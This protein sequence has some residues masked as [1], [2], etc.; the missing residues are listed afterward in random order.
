MNG[1]ELLAEFRAT[2]AETAFSEL[3]RRYTN[4]V[5]S[6]ANRRV[7]DMSLAQEVTQLV[8]IRLAKGPPKLE[9]EA[10]LLAWLH[11]ATVHVSIDLWRSETRRRAR[12]QYAGAM[13]TDRTE[14]VAWNEMSPVLDEALD[15]LDNS[16]REILLLRFFEQKTMADLGR[17]LEVSEDAAKMRVSRALNR[18]RTRLSGIGATCSAALLGTLLYER[19]V[20]AAP[21]GPAATLATIR[22]AAPAGLAS[23]LFKLVL[24]P[25]GAKLVPKLAA[26]IVIGAAAL[27]L[28][29]QVRRITTPRPVQGTR[30]Q[31][32]L[33]DAAFAEANSGTNSTGNG[34]DPDPV[35]LL[36]GVVRARKRIKSGIVEYDIVRFG[37]K[38]AVRDATVEY[39]L[40]IHFEEDHIWSECSGE[41]YAFNMPSGPDAEEI[42]K[43][44]YAM[45]NAQA[46][47]EGLIQP[48]TEHDV[49]FSDGEVEVDYLRSGTDGR[50]TI[51][52]PGHSAVFLFDPRC[53][54]H[55]ELKPFITLEWSLAYKGAKAVSLLGRETI[56]GNLAWH[57]R[58]KSKWDDIRDFWIDAAHPA[59]VLKAQ[60]NDT[61]SLSRYSN[62]DLTDPLP[63]EVTEIANRH[64]YRWE[65][66]RGRSQY[67]VSIDPACWTLDGLNMKVGTEVRDDRKHRR[68]GYWNGLGLSAVP[69][70]EEPEQPRAKRGE[71]L[72]LI[73]NEPGSPAGFGAALWILTNSPD[74]A[75]ARKAGDAIMQYHAQSPEMGRLVRDLD[76]MR[77]D[78]ATN[79]LP[80]IIDQN[81]DIKM[82][83]NACMVLA[84]F[85]KD[86]GENGK[87]KS[88]TS[89]AEKYYERVIA[90]FGQVPGEDGTTLAE[91]AEPPLSE[92]RR[93]SIG[94]VAPEIEGYDLYDNPMKL[95][96]QR[97]KIVALLFWD[98]WSN[99]LN[100]AFQFNSLVDQ[101]KGKPFILLGIHSSEN[102]ERAKA[103]ADKNGMNWS[104]IQDSRE[105]SI[106]KLYNVGNE[107]RSI[108]VLD[109]EGVIR[110]RGVRYP[111]DVAK[112]VE[113]LL[114]E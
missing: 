7:Y 87:N 83:G 51:I 88:A 10:Q 84:T 59:R 46:L 68:I 97:G 76:R 100:H 61:V 89:E 82:R 18:L 27:L 71:L 105:G 101:M 26:A 111:E 79:L 34:A 11:R 37:T 57:V 60:W 19:S 43:R 114:Q 66:V 38:V 81:P 64:G 12:E 108:Y 39:H 35:K 15:A 24:G 107:W 55:Y 41:R 17:I 44:A 29:H 58:V 109:R 69:P 77:P 80:S 3:V 63:T 48:Y 53:L 98:D 110:H 86:I 75:D 91:L 21:S 1:T 49:A 104:S 56:E 14:E 5:Y 67:N 28:F 96:E 73:D 22:I 6:I 103:A 32:S 85:L 33:S 23:G 2:R 93:L 70:K 72:A 74:G 40:K 65:F 16:D 106:H 50:T 9:S 62:S 113:K 112:A 54:G 45:P 13:Q 8:F 52:E 36:Q 94:K 25:P 95:S 78:C 90:E 99:D 31:G 30:V 4:L 92:L 20:Q 47:H 102:H 42:T